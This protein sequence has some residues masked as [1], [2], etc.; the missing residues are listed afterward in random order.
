VGILFEVMSLFLVAR[1]LSETSGASLTRERASWSELWSMLKRSVI[2]PPGL[3][4]FFLCLAGD[5]FVWGISLGTLFGMFSETYGL[6]DA[7]LGLMTSAM[8][9][10]MAITQLPVGRLVDRYGCKPSMVFSEAIGLPL[11]LMWA[12]SS[13]FEVLVA[14]YA[15]FGL[16]G[17]TWGPAV[18]AYLAARTSS[19]ERAEAI[20]RLS[21]FRGLL[22]FPAP[23]IGGL[24]F[25]RGGLRLPVMVSLVG[26][27]LVMM[28][29]ILLVKEPKTRQNW[30]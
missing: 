14:S 20:G 3:F 23:F 19:G 30:D 25:E 11:M 24:L 15:L 4:G 27:V 2:P 7:Q 26:I 18:M 21:A 17:S 9:V 13:R 29:I 16:V 6:T 12:F 28:G 22:A 5:S 1:F 8:S 10:S